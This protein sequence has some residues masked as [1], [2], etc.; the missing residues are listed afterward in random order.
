MKKWGLRHKVTGETL[1]APDPD[2]YDDAAWE[3]LPL[4]RAPDPRGFDKLAGS[5]IVEDTPL[6]ERVLEEE[7]LAGMTRAERHAEAVERAEARLLD[8]FERAGV[9]SAS[10]AKAMRAANPASSK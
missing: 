6:K 10:Q 2:N 4:D 8:K 7:R 5:A 1:F 3:K 9:I